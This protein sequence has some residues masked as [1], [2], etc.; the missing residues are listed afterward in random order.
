MPILSII[1]K[2]TLFCCPGLKSEQLP[3]WISLIGKCVL[4]T[5]QQQRTVTVHQTIQQNYNKAPL[6]YSLGPIQ[7][8]RY[9]QPGIFLP[10]GS[11][12]CW[13]CSSG[14]TSPSSPW[15]R[16]APR[17]RRPAGGT[18]PGSSPQRWHRK[19]WL[20]FYVTLSCLVLLFSL[21]YGTIL[22]FPG[23]I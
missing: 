19:I 20:K 10:G 6:F 23:T 21:F 17:P 14:D 7:N 12:N 16:P 18:S 15:S 5:A 22:V 2:S 4:I 9:S 3:T 13:G 8:T 1:L 11:H